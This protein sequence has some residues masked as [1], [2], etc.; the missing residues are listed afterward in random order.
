MTCRDIPISALSNRRVALL[1]PWQVPAFRPYLSDKSPG[2][3]GGDNP[4]L[5]RRYHSPSTYIPC[6]NF[7][8][9]RNFLH[10]CPC[11]TAPLVSY[12]ENPGPI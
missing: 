10:Y 5:V 4:Y 2:V 9:Q 11:I 1:L 3:R 7:V 6:E 12:H 8:R